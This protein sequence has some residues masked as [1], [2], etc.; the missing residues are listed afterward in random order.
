MDRETMHRLLDLCIGID[1]L[2]ETR[3]VEFSAYS[4]NSMVCINVFYRRYLAKWEI[5]DSYRCF[6]VNGECVWHHG[7]QET[8][9]DKVI[10]VLEEM[11]RAEH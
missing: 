4:E 2:D 10:E 1:D 6:E 9:L 8:T 5:M 3:T 7:L 11:Q